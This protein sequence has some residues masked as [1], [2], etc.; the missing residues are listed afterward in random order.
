MNPRHNRNDNW[1]VVLKCWLACSAN[2][3]VIIWHCRESIAVCSCWKRSQYQYET[4]ATELSIGF[5]FIAKKN[6]KEF[7]NR[8]L[9]PF[10]VPPLTLVFK[11]S[12]SERCCAKQRRWNREKTTTK[13]ELRILETAAMN[14]GSCGTRISMSLLLHSRSNG[15]SAIGISTEN[16]FF[17]A[18]YV[19]LSHW[20]AKQFHFHFLDLCKSTELIPSP[21]AALFI[22]LS[23]SFRLKVFSFAPIPP[24]LLTSTD[25]RTH[26]HDRAE[27]K[28]FTKFMLWRFIVNVL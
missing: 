19:K 1:I 24:L 4:L 22:F 6:K 14:V 8:C 23:S 17:A 27:C 10:F 5:L 11:T 21:A 25:N 20:S 12:Q 9:C 18:V 28:V 7:S 2:S 26:E 15:K 3:F 13:N 16:Y